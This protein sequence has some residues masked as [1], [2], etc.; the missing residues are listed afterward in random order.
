M[1]SLSKNPSTILVLSRDRSAFNRRLIELFQQSSNL[2]L[3]GLIIVEDDASNEAQPLDLPAGEFASQTVSHPSGSSARQ[4]LTSHSADLGIYTNHQ[5]INEGSLDC[6]K[7]GMVFFR[8]RTTVDKPFTTGTINLEQYFVESSSGEWA[9][10]D[11]TTFGLEQ[12][13]T[14]ES[15][16]IK[17]EIH[18]GQLIT[19]F[20]D[21]Y[22]PDQ[23]N[24]EESANL[25]E[26]SRPASIVRELSKQEQTIQT[27]RASALTSPAES[28]YRRLLKKCYRT[29]RLG[30]TQ[31]GNSSLRQKRTKLEQA[32]NAPVIFLYYHGVGC[33]ADNWM[34]LP[35]ETFHAQMNYLRQNIRIS[36]VDSAL[37]KLRQEENHRTTVVITF[38]DGYESLHKNL[39]PYMNFYDLPATIFVCPGAIEQ[40]SL[41]EHDVEYNNSDA[42]L[43]SYDQLRS[44]TEA[45]ATIGSHGL[46]HENMATLSREER[47]KSLV[48][49]RRKLKEA[50]HTE[51]DLFAFPFGHRTHV[52]ADAIDDARSEYSAVFSAFGG[53]NLPDSNDG[54]HFRRIPNPVDNGSLE[55]IVLGNHRILNPYYPGEL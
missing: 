54:F 31:I 14:A 6:F 15:L 27:R 30:Y 34:T 26:W 40:G 49:S 37:S 50:L 35:L 29:I 4:F 5:H 11:S 28:P 55:S 52:S 18:G 25:D 32:G 2:T 23:I 38:D 22:P 17:S 8:P 43:M 46:H 51:V 39:R 12:F 21:N 53:Y 48:Q 47:E 33:G 44:M 16:R 45:G 19:R 36:D 24:L 42:T 9:V 20:A 3:T 41:L 13:D 1:N 7:D 10:V